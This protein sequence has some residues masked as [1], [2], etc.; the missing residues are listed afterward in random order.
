M[1]EIFKGIEKEILKIYKIPEKK[2]RFSNFK[3]KNKEVNELINALGFKLYLHQVKALK[4]LYNKKDVVVTTSTASGK[5][6][7]FRLAIF[8]NFLSNPNDRY[9]LI[10]P[11]RALINNQYEKF[12]MENELFYKIT[13]KRVKAEILT[14]DVSL[15]KR[16]EILKDK[17]NVLFTT[18][19]MLH[20]QIL[21]N[22]ESY[23]WLLKNL[24]LLVVDELHVY[25]GV[26]GTNMVYVFKRLLKLLEKLNNNPQILCL[27]ATL[28]NPKEFAKLLFNR[29][30]EVVDKSYNPSS[31][32]Y[33]T[34]LEPKNLDNKQLLRRLIENLIN[35]N[36]KT[37]VFFDT[38]KETEKLM[39]FLLNSNVFNRISTYK[40]TL[41]KYI[42]EEVEEKFKN[43]E[44]LGLLTTNALELG[45]DIG[46]LD[47]V[48]NYGIPPDG[49]FSLI[50][51]FGRAGRRNREALNIIILRK[52]GLDY[53][54]K[55]NLNELYEKIR[56]GIIE[57]MPVNVTNRFVAKK[58]LHYLISE[59]KII[60]WEELNDF[61][62][63]IAKELEKEGKVKIYKNLITNKIEI[64][65]VKEP[66]YSS[67]RTASD[68]SY[69]LILDKPWIKNKLLNKNQNEILKFINWL[70]IKGY[71]IEEVDKD[72]YFRSLLPGMPYFSRGRLFIAKDKLSFGKF[73]FIF[74]DELDIFWDVEAQQ[75]KEEE[76][77]ILDIYHK[78][79]YKGIDIYH[80]K[81]RVRKIY[82]GFIVKGKNID[83]FY[84]ELLS[85]KDNG[86]L[87]AEIEL[88]KDFFGLNFISVRFKKEIIR[89]FETDGIWYVF[90]DNI[91]DVANEEFFEF[92]NVIEEDDLAISIYRDRKLSRK[93]LFPIY[94]GA[95]THYIKNVIKNRVKKHLN[96]K[97]DTK[98]VELLT[99]KIKKLID[100][101]DGIVGGLH[102]IEHN[103]I[104][105]TPIFTYIDSR[106]IGGYSYERFNKNPFKDK[107]VIFIYDGNE[108]GFG[109]AEILYENAERLLNK[110]LEHL[111]N[112]NCIDG[113]PLCIYSTKCG[114]FNEFLDKWQAIR[115]LKKLIK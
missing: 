35:N 80:G 99:Y 29:D 54:Y 20:Y 43:G 97:K 85:L 10:Y 96:V 89:D 8:D 7:I 77:D 27:S 14:G 93:E 1:E 34:I 110:S 61:E 78:K 24:K 28:R 64:K 38:R 102:A 70:K 62:K 72:E 106:E 45:I 42:R 21:K 86:I 112:C 18:P 79:N 103:I 50:Q 84:Q 9:L 44:I 11:T 31:R 12:S 53:Y 88:F 15:E 19:D 83:N 60:N 71:V 26:F 98:K 91:R 113:C 30:F 63:E 4:Y 39:R 69:Y 76:I 32:K 67:I 37:L 5:S 33:L 65:I 36:I 115:I 17:P 49:I 56:K 58:H 101:K 87:D 47:A 104:K 68:E 57:Y 94:L 46:D 48:I 55:E 92:L 73:N 3:F 81:L 100:S 52:D 16:K 41:P 2:G 108:G 111:K 51:R 40:G 23:S 59:L 75:K 13:N 25:R 74:A 95:T 82:S 90:P 114:T 66:T 107:A 22:H 105:I 6:E 109:L